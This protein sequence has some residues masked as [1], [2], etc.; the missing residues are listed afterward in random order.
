MSGLHAGNYDITHVFID[1]FVKMV[2]NV[3]EQDIAEFLAW[4]NAFSE[5]ENVT[6]TISMSLDPENVSEEIKKYAV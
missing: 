6:F 1:N 5:K 4:L 3:S 2:K